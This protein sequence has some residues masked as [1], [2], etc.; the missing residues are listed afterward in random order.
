METDNQTEMIL[1][2]Y[3]NNDGDMILNPTGGW[4]QFHNINGNEFEIKEWMR[5]YARH[6]DYPKCQI[7]KTGTCTCGLNKFITK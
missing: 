5:K 1:D 6:A 4:V 3:S 2:R 7:R